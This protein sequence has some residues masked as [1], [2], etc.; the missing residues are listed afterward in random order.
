M[1]KLE[2]IRARAEKATPGPWR[3]GGDC[4]EYRSA[5]VETTWAVDGEHT[6]LVTDYLKPADADFIA[7]SRTDI[8]KL[9]AALEAVANLHYASDDEED[10]FEAACGEGLCRH[11]GRDD[12]CPTVTI[13]PCAEC[14]IPG[15]H[16]IAYPCPT[17]RTIQEALQ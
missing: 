1:K 16:Y 10:L 8:P 4:E 17:I 2:E 5:Y 3:T 6:E 14:S 7:H 15:V 11:S 12:E 9:V 13:T